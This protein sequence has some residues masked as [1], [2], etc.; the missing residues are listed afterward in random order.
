MISDFK[1]KFD[2]P[3]KAHDLTMILR[4]DIL[5]LEGHIKHWGPGVKMQK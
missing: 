3:E 5:T 2:K 4:M 1:E